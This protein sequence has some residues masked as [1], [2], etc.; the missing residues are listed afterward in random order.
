MYG[1][2][3]DI[4]R[5]EVATVEPLNR[6]RKSS[7]YLITWPA[8]YNEGLDNAMKDSEDLIM[9]KRIG[10]QEWVPVKSL[11]GVKFMY[12]WNCGNGLYILTNCKELF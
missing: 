10:P 7:S 12:P 8:A 5:N 6:I 1:F 3:Y 9:L 4:E 11:S 2:K